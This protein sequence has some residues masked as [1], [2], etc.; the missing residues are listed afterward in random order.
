MKKVL[1]LF[2]VV[3][4]LMG[5]SLVFASSFTENN[6]EELKVMA[7]GSYLNVETKLIIKG[8]IVLVPLREVF[9]YLDAEVKWYGDT[10]KIGVTYNK[11]VMYIDVISKEITISDKIIKLN[12]P[13]VVINGVSMVDSK[14]VE[15]F[16]L[17]SV[18]MNTERNTL[19]INMPFKPFNIF[20]YNEYVKYEKIPE[21]AI[22][23][24]LHTTEEMMA[25]G[26]G[27][28]IIGTAYNNAVI[29][30]KY[31]EQFDKI[32]KLA[33]KYPSFEVFLDAEPDFVFGRSSAFSSKNKCA[34]ITDILNENIGVYVSKASYT[35][36]SDF[37]DVY[38][39]FY[40]LGKI[41]NIENRAAF[42]VE[43]MKNRVSIVASKVNVSR[44]SKVFV[45][46][47]GEDKAFTAGKS[48]ETYI[49]QS[50]G[51]KNIFDDIDKTWSYVNWET[52][53]D[54]NP[55]VIVI[56][57]YGNTSAQAKIDFLKS[58]AMLQ[59]I[60]AIKNEKFIIVPLPGIF[61]G[62]RVVDSLE[63]IAKG[64]H[65]TLFE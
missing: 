56:N 20:T 17:A 36:N 6:T 11:R 31:K 10:K 62:E 64:L 47:F 32:P 63:T 24:N 26:L 15:E 13:V 58:N 30:P 38:E 51:G 18:D 34:D 44:P 65:S 48:L 46:D 40:N 60:N 41:F 23:M 1:S 39:D 37:N 50:A 35:N 45:Y 25:L 59:S 7:D 53:V 3:F 49:I 61:P 14:L 2:I 29:L 54:R 9:E 55:D 16:F 12:E 22:S 4:L 8:D 57:D 42:L 5:S 33:D 28:K 43:D 52:V 21:R 19:L 27:E